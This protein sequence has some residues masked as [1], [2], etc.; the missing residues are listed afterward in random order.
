MLD[1]VGS[2]LD[3]RVFERSNSQIGLLV[4]RLFIY[5]QDV[6]ANFASQGADNN[7]TLNLI[8]NRN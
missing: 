4:I 6:F 7:G 8:E 3:I 1:I 2:A 5:L